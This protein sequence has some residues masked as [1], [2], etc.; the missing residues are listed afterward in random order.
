MSV[1]YAL[2]WTVGQKSHEPCF[3][4]FR[5]EAGVIMTLVTHG[6]HEPCAHSFLLWTSNNEYSFV[7]IS[8]PTGSLYLFV[9]GGFYKASKLEML[10]QNAAW[11]FLMLSECSSNVPPLVQD[12]SHLIPKQ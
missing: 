9:G 5:M 1:I 2:N 10:L 4:S 11:G 6:T 3:N 12:A 8:L 7:V